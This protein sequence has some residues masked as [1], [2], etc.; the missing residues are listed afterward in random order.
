MLELMRL[1]SLRCLGDRHADIYYRKGETVT[2]KAH[3]GTIDI[4]GVTVAKVNDKLQLQSVET[5]FDP[6]EM[7]RQIA[8]EGMVEKTAAGEAKGFVNEGNVDAT[9]KEMS[10]ATPAQCPFM[11]NEE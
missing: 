11:K 1:C 7:F 6:L 3:G 5:W 10:D 2:A 8:P 4:Q 9:L